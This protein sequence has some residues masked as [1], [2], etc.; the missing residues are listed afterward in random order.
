[1][2]VQES[3]A[4]PQT[5]DETGRPTP[6]HAAAAELEHELKEEAKM[7]EER[8]A[9]E[10]KPEEISSEPNEKGKEE[11]LDKLEDDQILPIDKDEPLP[12]S[13]DKKDE[14]SQKSFFDADAPQAT[15][16]DAPTTSTDAPTSATDAPAPPTT[17]SDAEPDKDL[18]V[19]SVP[20]LPVEQ[21]GASVPSDLDEHSVLSNLATPAEEKDEILA[22]DREESSES[23]R[24]EKKAAEGGAQDHV[25]AA[26]VDPGTGKMK[27]EEKK[28][29]GASSSIPVTPAEEMDFVLPID[30]NEVGEVPKKEGKEK[31]DAQKDFDRGDSTPYDA[32]GL[33]KFHPV[34]VVPDPPATSESASAPIEEPA[35]FS[36]LA[37]LPAT[38]AE[39]KDELLPIDREDFSAVEASENDEPSTSESASSSSNAASKPKQEKKTYSSLASLPT[40][41]ANEEKPLP[42]DRDDFDISSLLASSAS[43]KKAID[44]TNFEEA[45]QPQEGE[46]ISTQRDQ[47]EE[48]KKEEKIPSID[49]LPA[50]PA[51]EKDEILPID[52]EDSTVEDNVQQPPKADREAAIEAVREALR[53]EQPKEEPKEEPKQDDN[54]KVPSLDSLPATPAEEKEGMLPIDR[55]EPIEEILGSNIKEVDSAAEARREAAIVAVR[56]ALRKEQPKA[57]EQKIPSLDSLPATPAEEKEGMLPIDRNEPVEETLN[58]RQ[59]RPVATPHISSLDISDLPPTPA[60]EKDEILPI[61]KEEAS[62]A[63]AAPGVVPSAVD[64]DHDPE[65]EQQAEV[66]ESREPKEERRRTGSVDVRV[67]VE[68]EV[69]RSPPDLNAESLGVTREED[70]DQADEEK[71]LYG[72]D[73]QCFFSC[74]IFSR[75]RSSSSQELIPFVVFPSVF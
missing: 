59:Q 61:D 39:E 37:D 7:E 28:E 64:E 70:Q 56:E 32:P 1:M 15:A 21:P 20:L 69:H 68:T 35:P 43:N 54:A 53:K 3:A 10:I 47:P 6:H 25:N 46:L 8:K 11:K 50:T 57:E 2:L 44:L 9:K 30:K 58:V 5:P 19:N 42:I 24:V 41:P 49:S 34:S 33:S 73:G 27:D 36:S 23:S 13:D 51:E 26:F 63:P 48:E 52:R 66:E 67:D 4:V 38:P 40:T 18:P 45:F 16:T 55:D 22:I 72:E 71:P 31:A 17:K 29:Q 14:P 65:E 74:P 75:V 12:S 62:D 60:E